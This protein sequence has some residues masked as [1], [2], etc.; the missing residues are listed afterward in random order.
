[1]TDSAA[2]A[3]PTPYTVSITLD[4]AFATTRQ[5][6]F[7]ITQVTK[8]L[9]NQFRWSV[10]GPAGCGTATHSGGAP[11]ETDKTLESLLKTGGIVIVCGDSDDDD[12]EE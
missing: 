6:A 7:W 12:D 4:N 11:S 3:V 2:A 9:E 5:A 1:M 8:G 10:T